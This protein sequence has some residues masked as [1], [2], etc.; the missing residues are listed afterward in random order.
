MNSFL[1]VFTHPLP[2]AFYRL[3]AIAILLLTTYCLLPIVSLPTAYCLL[4]TAD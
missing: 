1:N 3:P 4:A 2:A